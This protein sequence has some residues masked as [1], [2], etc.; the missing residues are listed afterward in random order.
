MNII[1]KFSRACANLMEWSNCF[2]KISTIDRCKAMTAE[3]KHAKGRR[4]NEWRRER[5]HMCVSDKSVQAKTISIFLSLCR[6]PF[7]WPDHVNESRCVLF[8]YTIL[9]TIL[10][11]FRSMLYFSLV[12]STKS[13]IFFTSPENVF[14]THMNIPLVTHMSNLDMKSIILAHK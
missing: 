2:I 9:S 6:R 12:L 14:R 1:W 11:H 4:M 3:C 5:E 13:L 10:N 8:F 7:Y